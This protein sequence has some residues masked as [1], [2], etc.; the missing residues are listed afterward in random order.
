VVNQEIE[1]NLR[2]IKDKE[3]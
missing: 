1:K 3:F 2:I